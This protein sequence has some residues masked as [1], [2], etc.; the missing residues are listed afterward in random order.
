MY[1]IVKLGAAVSAGAVLGYVFSRGLLRPRRSLKGCKLHLDPKTTCSQKCLLA[2]AELGALELVPIQPVS[3]D[4]KAQREAKYIRDFHPFGKVPVLETAG[5]DRV[6]ETL[7][8]VDYL[9]KLSGSA[10]MPTDPAAAALTH[11]WI[12]VHTSYFKPAMFPV[13]AERILKP[14]RDGGAPDEQRVKAAIEATCGVLD[15]LEAS[16]AKS[17]APFL[18]GAEYTMADVY[19]TPELDVIVNRC[20]C[21][22]VLEGRPHVGAWFERIQRRQ[23]WTAN[24][25][26]WTEWSEYPANKRGC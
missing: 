6:Y 11:Q 22:G 20:G 2:L 1:A 19:F 7:A 16:L 15:V 14:R 24:K 12:S 3:L 4:A 18:A 10:L 9:S 26:R 23:A 8:I 25:S 17:G 21:T 5:G 13:Y